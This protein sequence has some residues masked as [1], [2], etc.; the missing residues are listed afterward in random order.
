MDTEDKYGTQP[1]QRELL[2][3]LNVFDTFCNEKGIKYSL[4]GGS[5][6]G[7]IRHNGIIPWDDD[8][9]IIAERENYNRLL[10]EIKKSQQF[11]LTRSIWIYRLSLK[12]N[13]QLDEASRPTLDLF[14]FDNVPDSEFVNGVKLALIKILQGMMKEAPS[15]DKYSFIYKICVFLTSLIGKLF[16]YS[17][18]F[19]LYHV[20]SQIG[21]KKKTKYVNCYNTM[22]QY[23][24][25]RYHNTLLE[26]LVRHKFD[27]IE[28]WITAE[29]DH[30]LK[31]QYG[32]YMILPS[33][34]SRKP[35]HTNF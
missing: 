35:S 31:N 12:E 1:I 3:L 27:D 16:P 28:A 11:Y 33:E 26:N 10:N 34:E 18:K 23:L 24:R 2:K 21:N 13:Q 30:Y 22:F 20:V 25:L 15:Y 7:A 6:L 29:Y 5:L 17:L 9:D 4:A 8:L 32:N 14:V 19:Y